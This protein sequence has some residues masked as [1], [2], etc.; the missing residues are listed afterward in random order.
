MKVAFLVAPEGVEQVELTD[1]W[2][3]VRDAG[4]TPTLISTKPGNRSCHVNAIA[5]HTHFPP[6]GSR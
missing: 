1:P 3:A 2:Q 5:H 4:G 6:V